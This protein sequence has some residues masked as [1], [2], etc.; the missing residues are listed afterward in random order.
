MPEKTGSHVIES[1][2]KQHPVPIVVVSAFPEAQHRDFI[3]E[4]AIYFLKKPF[5]VEAAKNALNAAA[6]LKILP[7]DIQIAKEALERLKSLDI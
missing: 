2:M 6:A 7:S 4:G 1:I 3:R 5:D